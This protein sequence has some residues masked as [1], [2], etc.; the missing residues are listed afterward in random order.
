[1]IYLAAATA[2][3]GILPTL[4]ESASIHVTKRRRRRHEIRGNSSADSSR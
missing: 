1:M 2:S 4:K 3:I